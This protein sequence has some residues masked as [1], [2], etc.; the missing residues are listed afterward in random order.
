MLSFTGIGLV[1]IPISATRAFGL[2]IGDKVISETV[3]RMYVKY[4][5]Q[6]HKVNELINLS[7]KYME[8]VYKIIKLMKLN[9]YLCI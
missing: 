6:Y 4:K 8:K 3:M 5:E 1:V 7:I 2:S 9:K